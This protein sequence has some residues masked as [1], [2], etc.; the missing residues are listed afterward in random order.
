METP[1]LLDL[2]F[3][4]LD[5]IFKNLDDS[6]KWQLAKV[7][8]NLGRAF[9][10]HI[11]DKYERVLIHYSSS[12]FLET[13]LPLCGSTVRHIE[14]TDCF[15]SYESLAWLIENNFE[16]LQSLTIDVYFQKTSYMNRFLRSGVKLQSVEIHVRIEL[17]FLP[18][19]IG[20]LMGHPRFKGLDLYY[21]PKGLGK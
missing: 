1:N 18:R 9:A 21:D 5:F 2:P 20:T 6:D 15:D 11:R 13:I 17:N 12:W 16:N 3:E 7:N 19:I 14:T 4:V 10:F 8:K